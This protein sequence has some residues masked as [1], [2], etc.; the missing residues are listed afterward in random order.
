MNNRL[1]VASL[2]FALCAGIIPK[3]P[4]QTAAAGPNGRFLLVFDTSS[5][6][7]TRLASEQYAVER[8]FFSMMNGQLQAGDTIGIWTFDRKLRAG[9]V[10]L[11]HWQPQYAA[12][13][14]SGVTNYLGHQRY[15]SSTRFATVMP[16]INKLILNSERLTVLIFCDGED[17]IKGTPFDQA[18]NNIFK[19]HR[20]TLRAGG[21]VFIVVLR[22]QF[23]QYTGY[24]VNSS[25]VGVSFPSFPPLP[26]P[27][28]QST[29]PAKSSQQF[30][31]QPPPPAVVPVVKL[32]PLVIVGTNVSTNLI[33]AVPSTPV[34]TN[35]PSVES[36]SNPPPAELKSH[37]SP[38]LEN[39]RSPTNGISA[40]TSKAGTNAAPGDQSPQNPTGLSR[41]A[42]LAIG[43]TLLFAAVMLIVVVLVR[44]RKGNRDSLISS[45]M[46]KK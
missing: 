15:S 13:I 32:P 25:G 2:A 12:S 33:P 10:P 8:L 14:A 41:N 34:L 26:E 11:Q 43:A 35:K 29:A 38:M 3:A 46:K 23:G 21:Q 19:E 37:P 44:S 22:S 31:T 42:A 39:S 17:E 9:E 6:M 40:N 7:K 24:T 27:A 45:A 4:A 28:T 5:A 1:I 30:P 20:R 18:I 16:D 36:G